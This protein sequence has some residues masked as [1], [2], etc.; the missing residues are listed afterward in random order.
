MINSMRTYSFIKTYLYI[1]NIFILCIYH[2]IVRLF[3][4]DIYLKYTWNL[5]LS[6]ELWS[7]KDTISRG[8]LKDNKCRALYNT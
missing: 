2:I 3:I 6:Q 7:L 4:G 1:R 8:S 5:R